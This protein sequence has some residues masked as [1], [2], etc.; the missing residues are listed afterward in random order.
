MS[1]NITDQTK[2]QILE[3]KKLKSG[4][5]V[6]VIQQGKTKHIYVVKFSTRKGKK[7]DVMSLNKA[8]DK[9]DYD[10]SF[11]SAKHQHF[12]DK[13]G[14]YSELDHN[15]EKRRE[16]YFKRHGSHNNDLSSPK[17][18]SHVFLWAGN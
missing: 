7:Y 13:L 9:L 16:N 8:G 2:P 15:D 12:K 3:F 14:G 4:D 6:V 10:L 1:S 18:W 5:W 17:W 11:G